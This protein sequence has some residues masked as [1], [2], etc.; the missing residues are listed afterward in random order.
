MSLK[1]FSLA[2]LVVLA[3]TKMADAQG[4]D[5]LPRAGDEQ[6]DLHDLGK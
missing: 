1:L 4:M 2:F 5:G 6:A 3:V